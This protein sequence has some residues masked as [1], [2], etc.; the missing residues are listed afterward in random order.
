MRAR[1]PGVRWVLRRPPG[2]ASSGPGQAAAEQADTRHSGFLTGLYVPDCV[3]DEH[4][5]PGRHSRLRQGDL[6]QVRGGFGALDLA[7]ERGIVD[8]VFGIEGGP[9]DTGLSFAGRTCKHY[10]QT[11]RL[12][13]A[14]QL[15]SARQ[16]PEP[17]PVRGIQRVM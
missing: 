3:A 12:A 13:R 8:G 6:D 1:Y 10:G 11:A 9:Q 17:G 7:G 14:E 15:N 4:R 2:A 16:R 5:L